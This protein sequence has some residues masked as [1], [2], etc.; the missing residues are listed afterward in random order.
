MK[1]HLI[2]PE[3]KA[4]HTRMAE[5]WGLSDLHGHIPLSYGHW[6]RLKVLEAL[7]VAVA[8]YLPGPPQLILD[9]GCG[10][11][12][13]SQI[14]AKRWERGQVVGADFSHEMLQVALRR[15]RVGGYEDRF[16][17]IECNLEQLSFL[18]EGYVDLVVSRLEDT[19]L[20][21]RRPGD[22]VIGRE[23]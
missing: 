23:H 17:A 6:M 22:V 3:I 7:E 15:A 2:G 9:A 11:G 8:T 5:M 4:A 13:F 12:D 20:D 16:K 10:N 21:S 14:L 1:E 19:T 18:P